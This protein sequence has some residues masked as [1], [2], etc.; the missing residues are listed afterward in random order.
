MVRS[1]MTLATMEAAAMA[2]LFS[3]P[4]T[5]GG[6]GAREPRQ[7]EAVDE[8][9]RAVAAPP[10]WRAREPARARF[11]RCTPPSSIDG[12][13]TATT[14]TRR[15]TASTCGRSSSRIRGVR[16]LESSR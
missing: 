4:S 12:T 5:I 11:A 7:P 15:A 2:A 1:R 3:S 14:V 9:R 8:V 10:G 16:R 6:M 13:G